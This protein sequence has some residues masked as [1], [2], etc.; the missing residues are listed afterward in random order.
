MS[1]IRNNRVKF[2]DIVRV[3][4]Q[5]MVSF[6]GTMVFWNLYPA[7][8]CLILLVIPWPLIMCQ[9]C[10]DGLLTK[11][12]AAKIL[13]TISYLQFMIAVSILTFAFTNYEVQAIYEHKQAAKA[14][15][16]AGLSEHQFGRK[17]RTERN[18]WISLFASVCWV[19]VYVLNKRTRELE[20]LRAEVKA[21]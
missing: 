15:G 20:R 14:H 10:R 9:K 7:W 16:M 3:Y 6:I 11:V 5:T 2:E 13:N 21:K 4:Q 8:F 1:T 12:F 19:V 17:L 18:W